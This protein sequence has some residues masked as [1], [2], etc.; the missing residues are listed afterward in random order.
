MLSEKY[1]IPI[2]WLKFDAPY[3]GFAQCCGVNP[4]VNFN[5]KLPNAKYNVGIIGCPV[6]N[7]QYGVIANAEGELPERVGFL[8]KNWNNDLPNNTL[9]NFPKGFSWGSLTVEFLP[10]GSTIQWSRSFIIYK[11]EGNRFFNYNFYTGKIDEIEFPKGY[12]SAY[13]RGG[14]QYFN[15]TVLNYKWKKLMEKFFNCSLEPRPWSLYD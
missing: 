11:I 3:I 7:N 4:K 5:S 12:K 8:Y 14:G 2:D 9:Y 10:P 6:C 13:F 15:I 1:K